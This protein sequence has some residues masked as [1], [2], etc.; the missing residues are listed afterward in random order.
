LSGWETFLS[1]LSKYSWRTFV[2]IFVASGAI[3]LFAEKLGVK[4]WAQS[5]RGYLVA[6]F[7]LSGT[8]AVTYAI[9]SLRAWAQ[10]KNHN[11]IDL[12]IVSGPSIHA[13]WSIGMTPLGKKPMLMLMCQI[14]FAHD[15]HSSVIVRRAYLKHAKEEFPTGPIVINPEVLLHP[16]LVYIGVTPVKARPGRILVGRLVFVD[17][18]NDK[19]TSD[20]IAFRPNTVPAEMHIKRLQTCIAPR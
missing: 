15:Q 14:D 2:G 13:T 6:A 19:H 11:V 4:D 3:L 10:E 18:F 7:I 9:T 8:V 16:T 12:R 1:E 5:L 20:K 17:Q